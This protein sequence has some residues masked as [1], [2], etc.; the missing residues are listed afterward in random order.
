MAYDLIL[1]QTTDDWS[2]EGR[3]G[4]R[5]S[6]GADAV[7]GAVLLGFGV[8]MAVIKG[9]KTSSSDDVLDS[10]SEGYESD[11]D[12]EPRTNPYTEL[13]TQ[14]YAGHLSSPRVDPEPSHE[15]FRPGP[16]STAQRYISRQDRPTQE[17]PSFEP[18]RD[19]VEKGL[20]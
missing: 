1:G 11:H 6:P 17:I 18:M 8:V 2:R 15:V 13:D 16:S 10:R 7:A 5:P 3:Q 19:V 14:P 4:G 12:F 9:P 20:R